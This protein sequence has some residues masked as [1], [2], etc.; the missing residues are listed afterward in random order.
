MFIQE[1]NMY[2]TT[3]ILLKTFGFTIVLCFCINTAFAEGAATGN[4]DETQN[5]GTVNTGGQSGNSGTNTSDPETNDPTT[6]SDGSTITLCPAGQYVYKCG[7]YRVGLEWLKGISDVEDNTIKTKT[8]CEITNGGVWSESDSKCYVSTR[9][10]YITNNQYDLLEQM[11]NLFRAI[12]IQYCA[13]WDNDKNSC[14]KIYPKYA[15]NPNVAQDLKTILDY[16]CNPLDSSITIT[17]AYCPDSANVPA[18]KVTLNSSGEKTS[19][20]SFYTIADCYMETFTDTTGTYNYYNE[21]G[22]QQKCY[23]ANT[24]SK[25]LSTLSGDNIQNF[26]LGTSQNSGA[27]FI[28]IP[29]T[30]TISFA[31]P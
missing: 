12:G 18:S 10:Y 15:R 3:K 11:R 9:N 6:T 16:V 8:A 2:H 28:N 26:T 24:N 20:W 23:Y 4:P 29:Q 22:T 1:R 13:T 17:C 7:N 14:T 31:N 25:A 30:A 19:N 27:V 5:A 21:S